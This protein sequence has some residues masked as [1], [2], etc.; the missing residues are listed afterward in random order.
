MRK[1]TTCFLT[2]LI[3]A[4][5]SF[6][7]QKPSQAQTENTHPPVD[8]MIMID[9]SCSMFPANQIRAECDA[10]GSDTEFLRIAGADMF[11]ARLGFAESN[12]SEYQMGVISF[13]DEPVLVNPLEPI[14]AL[15]D[16]LAS[17]IARPLPQPA[18][19]ILP[20]ME[21]AYSE[22]EN[23]P[24]RRQEHLPAIVLITDGVPWPREDQSDSDI[25]ALIRSHPD[26]PLFIMLLQNN[27]RISQDY[28]DYIQFWHMLQSRYAHIFVYPVQ[29]AS[30]IEDTYNLILGQI[31]NTIPSKA[32]QVRP[33]VPFSFF[34][35]QYINK[36]VITVIRKSGTT[37]AGVTIQDPDGKVVEADEPGVK[38]FR[39][40]ENPIEV[41][42]IEAPRL[43]D[44]LKGKTWSVITKSQVRIIV[45]REGSYRINFLTP[46]VASTDI[47]N[48]FRVTERQTPS[49]GVVVRFNLVD[50]L[51]KP[52]L[53][54]QEISGSVINPD[55][56]EAPIPGIIGMRPDPTGIYEFRY[57]AATY[58]PEIVENP[59]R[60][61][62][63][64][65]VGQADEQLIE[66][67]PVTSAR[68][69]MDIGETPFIRSVAPLPI[70]CEAGQPFQ[71]RVSLGDFSSSLDNSLQVKLIYGSDDIQLSSNEPGVYTGDLTNFCMEV[72]ARQYCSSQELV[73]VLV[74]LEASLKDGTILNPVMRE[75]QA[76]VISPVCTPT[77]VPTPTATPMPTAT[78][79]PDSDSDGVNDLTDACPGVR[80]FSGFD[81]CIPWGWVFGG[82]GFLGIMVF[83]SVWLWPFIRVR[84][85]SEP[86]RGYLLIC[87]DGKPLDSPI[88]LYSLGRE[89]RAYRIAVGSDSN[90]ALVVVNGLRSVEFIIERRSVL[91]TVRDPD[92]KEPF[93]FLDD[94][95]RL[96]RTSDPKVI[97]RLSMKREKLKC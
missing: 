34:A 78:P 45:D 77:P 74:Q 25:E 36:V 26:T 28:Q 52:I 39:G 53:E 18:T 89:K 37:D 81:G 13:G 91:T 38:Y 97:I 23:S 31:Q 66:Q 24:N 30:Q 1:T 61:T 17:K 3:I 5:L 14:E 20:A 11:I 83:S 51:G 56:I 82:L 27:A 90:R 58:Y 64:L 10:W 8:M 9:N 73:N 94:D 44:D 63:K 69:L 85:V 50:S 54:P 95:V 42:S 86:P 80:G 62:F 21:M 29:E 6:P 49:Q 57:N 7:A 96:V 4:L 88:D 76:Q 72:I 16:S 40:K 22:L 55:G 19:R 43:R 15:R 2:L 67:V 70:T 60:F 41:Y 12:E 71:I 75:V 87:K 32:S 35:N 33:G 47:N 79:V 92:E 68:L 59:G 93:A 65:A 46:T 84:T 48:F